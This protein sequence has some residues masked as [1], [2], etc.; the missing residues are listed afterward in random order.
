ML[1]C[2]AS[3]MDRLGRH[4]AYGNSTH[5][6]HTV[7]DMSPNT[8][9][10]GQLKCMLW[11]NPWDAKKVLFCFTFTVF[12]KSKFYTFPVS[13]PPL[14]FIHCISMLP[15]S[16]LVLISAWSNTHLL[17]PSQ[18]SDR[19]YATLMCFQLWFLSFR[20]RFRL[21]GSMMYLWILLGG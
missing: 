1:F 5:T 4:S 8:G 19:L 3:S 10:V 7:D 12:A 14:S 6:H 13:L 11:Q 16:L 9:K 17:F 20:R 2:S 18:Q 15:L 21:S